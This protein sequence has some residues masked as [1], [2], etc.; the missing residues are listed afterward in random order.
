MVENKQKTK[1]FIKKSDLTSLFL[2]YYFDKHFEIFCFE[3]N[4]N[5]IFATVI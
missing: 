2:F 4:N 5:I 3:K 1:N